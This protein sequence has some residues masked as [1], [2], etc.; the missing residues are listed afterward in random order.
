MFCSIIS[1][2]R[3]ACEQ[4][5]T[6]CRA[7]GAS[8]GPGHS[9]LLLLPVPPHPL[10]HSSLSAHTATAWAGLGSSPQNPHP[11]KLCPLAEPHAPG[12]Q[13]LTFA[14]T[15]KAKPPAGKNS[16]LGESIL[17]HTHFLLFHATGQNPKPAT[18]LHLWLGN[19][20]GSFPDKCQLY[21]NRMP[22]RV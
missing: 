1:H 15:G 16:H 2:S 10:W 12:L 21:S 11:R 18:S 7:A 13:H 5:S 20:T 3:G 4:Q 17:S 8:P 9:H 14:P 19:N 22:I 6:S